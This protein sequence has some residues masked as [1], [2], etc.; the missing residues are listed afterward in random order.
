LIANSY[1]SFRTHRNYHVGFTQD[2]N[3]LVDTLH[4][5][6]PAKKMYLCG[7]SLG[8]NVS[9]KYLGELGD[10]ATKKGIFGAAVTCV[11][12][13]LAGSQAKLDVGFNR[14]MYSMVRAPSS[15]RC[16]LLH[17][18]FTLLLICLCVESIRAF[19]QH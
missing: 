1:C 6:Y 18:F 5:R 7:F 12:F 9:L 8:G 3:Q 14:A 11:P 15:V 2:I 4:G 16:V 13:D 17:Q 19:W 10:D